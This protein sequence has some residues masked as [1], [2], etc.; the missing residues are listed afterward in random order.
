MKLFTRKMT[1]EDFAGVLPLQYEIQKLH[2]AGRPDL[3][4]TGAV[5]YPEEIFRQTVNDPAWRCAVCEAD[6]EIAGFLFAWVR[7]LHDH[8]NMRDADILLLDDICVGER[9]RRHGVGR[10]LFAY[11]EAAAEEAGC[12]R[13]EL[14]LWSFNEDAAAFYR[15]MGLRPM[16][17]KME[18]RTGQGV[19]I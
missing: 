10:A 17:V 1:E 13:I 19:E 3:F 9:F 18:K 7:R 8:R 2:K 4:R 16:T 6:G 11:A 12:S 14:S 15:A 5:S